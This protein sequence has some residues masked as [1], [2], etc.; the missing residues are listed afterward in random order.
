[1]KITRKNL[2]N[3]IKEEMGK[4]MLERQVAMRVQSSNN[5][6][7]SIRLIKQQRK[8]KVDTRQDANEI[9]NQ[10]RAALSELEKAAKKLSRAGGHGFELFED[11]LVGAINIIKPLVTDLKKAGPETPFLFDAPDAFFFKLDQAI[12]KLDNVLRHKDLIRTLLS[13]LARM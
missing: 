9:Y 1:M 4:L 3:I 12:A 10:L 7:K 5:F 2:E 8:K 13:G 11:D 6:E